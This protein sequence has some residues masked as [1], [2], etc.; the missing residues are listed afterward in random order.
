M[1][2]T[3]EVLQ[4]SDV[5]AIPV[6]SRPRHSLSA[7][8]ELPGPR[9]TGKSR[10]AR[11]AAFRFAL[12]GRIDC[13]QH[14]EDAS[15]RLQSCQAPKLSDSSQPLLSKPHSARPPPRESPTETAILE[16]GARNS[17]A[18]GSAENR[19]CNSFVSEY[20][21]VSSL[22]SDIYRDIFQVLSCNCPLFEYLQRNIGEG[23]SRYQGAPRHRP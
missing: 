14:S 23:V 15:P 12:G 3:R 10:F 13:T 6:D 5:H 19:S 11:A 4:I 18:S 17:A 1:L 9:S 22:D 2:L 21:P 16:L 8:G 20:L 7:F